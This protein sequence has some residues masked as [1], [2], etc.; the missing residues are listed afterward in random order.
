M[1]ENLARKLVA[2]HLV[3]GRMEPGEEVAVRVDQALLQDATGTLA[4]LEFEAM[5]AP[6]LQVRQATQYVDHNTLQTGYENPDDHLFLQG[7][8]ARH[9]AVFSKPGNGISHWAHLERFDVPGEAMLGADSHTPHAGASGMLAIGA[10]GSA[11][12]AA[13]AGVPY[14][15]R[16][17]EVH[18]VELRGELPPWTSAKDAILELLRRHN[19]RWGRYKA[20]EFTGPGLAHLTVPERGTIANMV[21]ELGCTTGVFPSDAMT[22]R[23]LRA[24]GRPGDFRPLAADEGAGYDSEEVLDLGEVEPLIALP[25]SPDKVVPVADA[26]GTRVLQVAV[27]SSVNSSF[28]DLGMVAHMLDGRT[29]APHVSMAVSPGSRRVLLLFMATGGMTKLLKAGVRELE[30]ACGPCIGMGFAPPTMGASARTFNRNFRGRSGTAEDRVF[31][32]SPE[33]AAA[34]ALRGSIADPR[35][36]A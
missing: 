25:H 4:W 7:M 19:V 5:G 13:M 17:P 9:G 22:E 3:E 12:A 15:F 28:R 27:G 16:M 24:Q 8:A 29:I 30:V 11:V 6:E 26:Q 14:A 10:G 35:D 31:L 21:T 2:A 36:V 20:L 33:T 23:W 32:C 34:T 1:P 18:R